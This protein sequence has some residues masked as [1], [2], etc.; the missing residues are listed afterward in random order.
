M[1]FIISDLCERVE[2]GS[3]EGMTSAKSKEIASKQSGN[4][5][6]AEKKETV[7]EEGSF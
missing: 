7:E 3:K 5:G 2:K 1:I 6:E 4:K